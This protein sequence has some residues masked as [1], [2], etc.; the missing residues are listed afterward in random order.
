MKR[1]GLIGGVS[2]ESSV[3]Y[4]RIINQTTQALLGKAHSCDCLLDSFDF[5]EVRTLQYEDRWPELAQRLIEKAQ[6]LEKGGAEL[7]LICSNTL[8]KMSEEVQG[9]IQIPIYHIAE[10]TALAIQ[11]QGLHTVGLLGTRFTMKEDFY[12]LHLRKAGI[13]VLVPAEEEMALVNDIIYNELVKGQIK[14]ESRVVYQQVIA[15]LEQKG[16]QGV[17][18]GCTEIPL[19]IKPEHSPIPVFDTTYIHAT[20]AVKKALSLA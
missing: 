17:I 3:E 13:S 14:E 10:A 9:Q 18:L 2:W 7:L 15:Q 19:L 12:K 16:A 11:E 6:L 1:I 4:Y 8:H 20:G 5:E